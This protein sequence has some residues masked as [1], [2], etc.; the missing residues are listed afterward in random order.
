LLP[1][2][3]TVQLEV[4]YQS[5]EP[6]GRLRISLNRAIRKTDSKEILQ[7]TLLAR[8]KPSTSDPSS[9]MDWIDAGRELVVKSFADFTTAEMH[10]IWREQKRK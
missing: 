2:P 5:S 10:Q 8:G 6:P 1:P 4:A 9:V 7:L 3:E